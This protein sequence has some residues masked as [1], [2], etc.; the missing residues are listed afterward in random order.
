MS[1]TV[2]NR[3]IG[4]EAANTP[5]SEPLA[6]GA[7][8]PDVP[9]HTAQH[10][11]V[12][13]AEMTGQTTVLVFSEND[14]NPARAEQMT[15]L[16]NALMKAAIPEKGSAFQSVNAIER[17]GSHYA[18]RIDDQEALQLQ[19]FELD[20]QSSA[21]HAYG[22]H[23]RQALFVLDGAGVIRWS[24]AVE[25]GMLPE[26]TPI[27]ASLQAAFPSSST[28]TSDSPAIHP[29]LNSDPSLSTTSGSTTS[30][31]SAEKAGHWLGSRREFV[32]TAFAGAL[33]LALLGTDADAQRTALMDPK[34]LVPST[35]AETI[36]VH[37]TI[38]GKRHNLQL[39]PRTAL[40][41]V[42]REHVGL[43]GSKKGCD[44]GQCGACT[45]HINGQR[46]LSCL[47][48]A[49]QQEGTQIVTIE[50]LAHGEKLH[51]MQ[52]AFLEYDGYQCGYCTSGQIMSAV[53]LLRE[54]NANSDAEIREGMSGNL[55]RCAAYPHIVSAVKAAR[56]SKQ[57]V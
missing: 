45:V 40:L 24:H 18:L 2:D 33:A 7:A 19:L 49:A 38:N 32:V 30:R 8:A 9:L 56:D 43:T 4:E 20:N 53:A 14:W 31:I 16:T 5:P 11:T 21:A 10:G 36:P 1:V 42:L 15:A 37:L 39:D 12:G 44:H 48:L 51:P 41:D 29:P 26:V 23:G 6:V 28:A 13:F 22:V 27:L 3:Y 54:G 17:E 25:P 52:A 34:R 47:S 55:C 57:R 46:V 50:G 35:G